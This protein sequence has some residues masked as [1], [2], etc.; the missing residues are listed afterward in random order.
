MAYANL[1][2]RQYIQLA[3]DEI[4][5]YHLD[6]ND[7]CIF[8]ETLLMATRLRKEDYNLLDT[9]ISEEEMESLVQCLMIKLTSF[10][11]DAKEYIDK[12]YA[13][14]H[15]K[16]WLIALDIISKLILRCHGIGEQD[17]K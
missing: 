13:Q 9:I 14:E 11:C 8:H 10:C 5:K 2:G 7:I 12:E 4:N 1:T 6:E 3:Q 15:H 16:T 17:G